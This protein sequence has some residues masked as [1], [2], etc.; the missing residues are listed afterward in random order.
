MELKK[1]KLRELLSIKNGRDHKSLSSGDY[2]VYGSG[3]LMRYCNDFLY[4]SPSI[5]LPRKGSLDNIQYADTPFWT[6]DTLYYTEIN[7]AKANPYYLLLL[8]AKVF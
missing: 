2:P 1:Y 8:S 7:A 4:D 3:G 5:L 6:V